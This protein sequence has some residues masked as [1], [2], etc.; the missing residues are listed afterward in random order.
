MSDVFLFPGQGAE[1]PGMGGAALSRPGPV[2]A[3]LER[4]SR[5]LGRDLAEVVERGGPELARTELGQPALVAISLG[6]AL[7]SGLAP[8]AVAGH[9][10]GELAAFCAAGCLAPE[11]AID[12]V[13]DRSRL[14]ADAARGASGGMAAIRVT[15]E[16]QAREAIAGEQGL[17]I[18]AHNGPEEWVLTG[19]RAALAALAARLPIVLLP[20]TGP[21]HSRAMAGAAAQWR[22][23]LGRVQWRRPRVPVVANATGRFITDGEDLAELLASQLTQPVQWARTLQTLSAAGASRWHV[24]GPGRVLR[25]LCRANLGT[26]ATVEL[27]E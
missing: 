1:G 12:C 22:L 4:A 27:R 17:E 8:A 13:V 14:M 19:D 6:L 18:A 15:S 20:V 10:V 25:G 9:S 7:E 11:E 5:T 21:W 2:R 23:A 3:L 16:A 26:A 24:F